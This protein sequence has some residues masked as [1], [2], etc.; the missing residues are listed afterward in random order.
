[1][2]S[3]SIL[4]ATKDRPQELEACLSSI[5]V[6]TRAPGEIIV[7][8]QSAQRR[9]PVLADV[10]AD[11]G[12]ALRYVHAP[13]LTGLTHARN[14]A[15]SIAAG[16]VLLFL[17]DDVELDSDYL[18]ELLRV[19]DND[20]HGVVGGAGGLIVNFRSSLSLAQRIR[21]WLFYRGAFAI[22]RDALEFHVQPGSSPRP[23]KRLFGANMA[24][25][26]KVMQRFSFDE[27]YQGYGFGEDRDFSV[28]VAREFRL[29]WVPGARLVHH[30]SSR[31]R[32]S[33]E[34][35]CELRILSWRRFY[36]RCVAKTPY[37]A[38]CYLWLNA[39]FATLLLGV[40]DWPTVRGTYRG[41]RRLVNILVG[42][43]DLDRAL[44][45]NWTPDS[46]RRAR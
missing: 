19:F 8:D 2:N 24:Y 12:V 42:R 36:N 37:A 1:V 13:Q 41:L 20:T 44:D 46:S 22:E 16:D 7:V 43:D 17:D 23:A 6:Q 11:A 29:T 28:Y 14:H 38:V 32:L 45:G 40:W 27:G 26:Q 25:R 15:V 4:I 34:R 35:F 30:Q 31:S 9:P 33:R 5:L 10:F 3:V 21:S 18:R 39:G